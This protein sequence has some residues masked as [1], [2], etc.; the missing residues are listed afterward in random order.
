[1]AIVKTLDGDATVEPP[2]AEYVPFLA[3][4][5]ATSQREATPWLHTT[6]DPVPVRDAD[7][8]TSPALRSAAKVWATQPHVRQAVG[9]IASHVAS[10]PL[11]LYRR[12]ADSD[13]R[14]V[15]VGPAAE[16]LGHPSLLMSTFM[17]LRD[18]ST[19][20]LVYD[21]ALAVVAG[22]EL[23]RIPPSLFRIDSDAFGNARRLVLIGE[24]AGEEVDVTDAPRILLYG[25][26]AYRAGGV[27]PLYT[28]AGILDENER[29]VQW[30]ADQWKNAAKITGLLKRPA[31]ERTWRPEQRERFEKQWAEWKSGAK[32]GG[33]PI[34]EGGMEYE[35]LRGFSPKDANDIEGR[36]LSAEEVAMAFFLPPE[37]LGIRKGANSSVE[38]Y[39]QMLYGPVLGPWLV[40]LEQAINNQLLPRLDASEDLY[41][42]FNREAG[43]AGSFKEQARVLQASVGRPIMTAAEARA[44]MNLP[45]LEGTDE[46]VTPMNLEAGS[47]GD[48][49]GAEAQ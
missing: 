2:D 35:E 22:G 10:L 32:A 16:L 29:A 49:E 25:W 48:A 30:R 44:M 6:N 15:T 42:E 3:S 33:T 19:D 4:E 40:E 26:H 37:L 43:L 11:H 41:A 8:V 36:Q 23:V 39:R 24:N 21:R 9:Y 1:M 18:L 28:L 47:G 45:F 12:H 34:L 17:L 20:R 13:R 27:S 46:L 14:R 7:T 38:A 5:G 31:S